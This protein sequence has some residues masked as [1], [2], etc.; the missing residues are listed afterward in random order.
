MTIGEN[1]MAY[2]SSRISIE[3]D[4]EELF[5]ILAALVVYGQEDDNQEAIGLY[6]S[7]GEQIGLIEVEEDEEE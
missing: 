7:I 6:E 2:C 1:K 5:C 3:V 4:L